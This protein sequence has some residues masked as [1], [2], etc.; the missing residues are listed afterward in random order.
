VYSVVVGQQLAPVS[1]VVG[2]VVRPLTQHRVVLEKARP[3]PIDQVIDKNIPKLEQAFLDMVDAVRR[4]LTNKGMVPFLLRQDVN[5]LLQYLDLEHRLEEAAK[6]AGLPPGKTSFQ[7]LITQVFEQGAQAGVQALDRVSVQKASVGFAMAFDALSPTALSFLS[8]YTFSLIREM[9]K[10]S[11][12]AIGQVVQEAFREGGH[13]YS[14]ARD[15]RNMIGLTRRQ[16]RAVWNFR[17]MLESGDP[18]KLREALTR[19]LRDRRFD[20]SIWR[21]IRQGAGI[22]RDKVD[23]MVDRYHQRYLQYRARTIA[24]TETIRASNAGQL[25]AWKQARQQGLLDADRTRRKWIVTIPC[26]LCRQIRDMNKDGVPLD[27]PFMG[28]DGPIDYPPAHPNCRCVTG[29]TFIAA[30]KAAPK[31]PTKKPS[32]PTY[33][34]PPPKPLE[35]YKASRSAANEMWRHAKKC[36]EFIDEP[37]IKDKDA[38]EGVVRR[39]KGN[40]TFAKFAKK[41]YYHDLTGEIRPK[42]I[43][44]A[45]RELRDTWATTSYDH[46]K[47]AIALQR[48]AAEEFGLKKVYM[49]KVPGYV[50]REVDALIAEHG[51][52]LRSYIRAV[53]DNT[54]AQLKKAGIEEVWLHRGMRSIPRKSLPSGVDNGA[55]VGK[56]SLQPMSSFSSEADTA[57]VFADYPPGPGSPDISAVVSIKVPRERIISTAA[58][59]FGE[60]LENEFIVAG[61]EYEAIVT[62]SYLLGAHTES[63]KL[64]QLASQALLKK[65]R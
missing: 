24:R 44:G 37:R 32:K 58:S 48:L 36:D 10:E 31:K 22:R 65:G 61:G 39:L 20:P 26:P 33:K 52:A 60:E 45:A 41:Y 34:L 15:I 16:S 29:L 47:I 27:E 55:V 11:R 19:A 40:K 17:R 50:K 51:D 46:D 4:Q 62:N 18:A 57:M 35:R 53:Y 13:P 1:K 14:Q 59:G 7:S 21:A 3:Q 30:P 9:S 49:R 6:G 8:G 25:E 54:Q 38:L 64:H 63:W 43:M 42:H 28:P 12:L 2:A 56:V 5:G 23:T